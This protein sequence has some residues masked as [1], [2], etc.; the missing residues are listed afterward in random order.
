MMNKPYI[1]WQE[2][3]GGELRPI[4]TKVA[5]VTDATL[6]PNIAAAIDEARKLREASA[7]ITEGGDR[8]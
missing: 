7:D 6:F 8:G 5:D 3:H 4:T 2:R 1:P